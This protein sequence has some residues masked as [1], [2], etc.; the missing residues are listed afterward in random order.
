MNVLTTRYPV[1]TR[2]PFASIFGDFFAAPRCDSTGV[3]GNS[4]SWTPTVDVT[5]DMDG[6]LFRFDVPGVS[7]ENVEVSVE[8]DVIT[9][10]GERKD[11]TAENDQTNVCRRETVYGSFKRA[12]RVPADAD[13]SKVA[14]EHTDGVLQLRVGRTVAA[15][16]RRIE[17]G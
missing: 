10:T 17:I 3:E 5:S 13:V 9:V 1:R 11:A 14:A 4:K 2:D 8:D 16:A 7:K 15:Q 6:Y 12:F